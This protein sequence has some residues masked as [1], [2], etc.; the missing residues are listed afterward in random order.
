MPRVHYYYVPKVGWLAQASIEDEVKKAVMEANQTRR[1]VSFMEVAGFA[2]L[3]F[4]SAFWITMAVCRGERGNP[5]G[6]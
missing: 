6:E 4:T 2:V 1:E 5:M 3:A